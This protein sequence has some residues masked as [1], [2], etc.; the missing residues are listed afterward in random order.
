MFSKWFQ[1]DPIKI[2][3]EDIKY[4][5]D[6]LNI[7]IIIN[8]LPVNE[9]GCLIKGTLSLETE[10]ATINSLIDDADLH[11]Q[12]IIVYGKNAV[13][14]SVD[15]KYNQLRTLGFSKLAIYCGGLFEWI[16]LQDIYGSSEFPTTGHELDLLKY[17]PPKTYGKL[18]LKG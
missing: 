4:A 17:R 14:S 18:L 10:T 8:T 9:Q 15:K 1:K 2:G 16:L 13:D 5:I 7:Y 12:T 11:S 6:N 3:F